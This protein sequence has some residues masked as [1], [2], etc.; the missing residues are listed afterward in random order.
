MKK[1]LSLLIIFAFIISCASPEVVNVI[2]PND[3]KLSCKELSNEIAKANELADK[4][5]QAKKM[6][7]QPKIDV[8]KLKMTTGQRP[9]SLPLP[10][11]SQIETLPQRALS[12]GGKKKK[13]QKQKR[14][15]NKKSKKQKKTRKNRTKR[16]K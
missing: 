3:N 14:S 11:N 7:A 5:Q 16:K 12:Y 1:T 8:S 10:Y 4:A 15:K 13:T 6:E 2:G 9:Q